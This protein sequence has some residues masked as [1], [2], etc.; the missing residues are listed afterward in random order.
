MV[1]AF[2]CPPK[3]TPILNKELAMPSR[4]PKQ[5]EM[6]QALTSRRRF[7]RALSTT[8]ALGAVGSGGSAA[9]FS[10]TSA[11]AAPSSSNAR[12]ALPSMMRAVQFSKYGEASELKLVTIPR[13]SP[14]DNEVLVRVHAAGINPVDWKVRNGEAAALVS[15]LPATL[16]YDLAGEIVAVGRAVNT[17]K[18]GERVFAMLPLTASGTY[19]DYAVV[20]ETLVAV[21]PNQS[22]MIEAAALPLA[23]LTAYQG[24]FE[25]GGL[26]RGKEK[27]VLIHGASG[28]VGHLA[29]QMARNSGAVVFGTAGPTN[30]D[31]LRSL[32]ATPIDHRSQKFEDIAKDIH[33]VFDTIGGDTL[34]RSYGV[35]GR[36]GTIVSL[37]EKPDA[38]TAQARGINSGDRVVVRP[39]GEGLR[40]IASMVDANTLKVEIAETAPLSSVIALTLKSESGRTRGKLV[41]D[42]LAS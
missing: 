37:L 22:T 23:A 28:G 2:A 9:L 40:R 7:L 30:Q 33:L 13:P 5:P 6:N 14:R 38:A 3:P 29:V 11:L 32:G 15:K 17:R 16:G 34:K 1:I 26:Q 8:G 36:G 41:L 39:D 31:F 10:S 35:I 42:M 25:A 21:A 19:A 27:R 24:L 4:T 12:T 20:P 18:V